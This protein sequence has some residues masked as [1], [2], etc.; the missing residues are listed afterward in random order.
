MLARR[1]FKLALLIAAILT[2]FAAC[3]EREPQAPEDPPYIPEVS[4]VDEYPD[5]PE[6]GGGI[7]LITHIP[8]YFVDMTVEPHGRRVSG[9]MLVDFVNTTAGYLDRV[10]FWAPTALEVSAAS[11]DLIHLEFLHTETKLRLYLDEPLPPRE[12]LNIALIFE[13]QATHISRS[14]GA[15]AHAMWFGNFL[16][17]LAVLD[18][19]GWIVHPD[20]SVVSNFSVNIT[21]GYNY[22]VVSTGSRV[23]TLSLDTNFVTADAVFVRD[24]AFAVLSPVYEGFRIH[25][26]EGSDFITFYHNTYLQ[27]DFYDYE[28]HPILYAA[29]LA[30]E[31]FEQTIAPNPHGSLQ[32]VEIDL[33]TGSQ[34]FPGVIFMDSSYMGSPNAHVSITREIAAQWF[35]G[36]VSANPEEPWLTSSLAS[37]LAMEFTLHPI[38]LS[39][40]MRQM[41]RSNPDDISPNTRGIIFLYALRNEIGSGNFNALLQAYYNH[42][43]FSIAT[44]AGFLELANEFEPLD[45]FFDAWLF[46]ETLPY[47]PDITGDPDRF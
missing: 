9:V 44:T 18:G 42:Y 35:T 33:Q 47:L 1:K 25:Y 30:W 27:T 4:I 15:N 10:Y 26:P 2:V 38:Q 22:H 23:S 28:P 37:F 13:G 43:A 39:Y 12:L 36:T 14:I 40:A 3:G 21:T 34:S 11:G 7:E 19:D 41:H 31:H 8:S 16:P 5:P 45:D 20:F 46:G 17:T 32:I 6:N 24:F 29:T